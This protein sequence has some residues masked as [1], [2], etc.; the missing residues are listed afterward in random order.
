MD[1]MPTFW[2]SFRGT[3]DFLLMLIGAALPFFLLAGIILAAVNWRTVVL[4]LL[5]TFRPRP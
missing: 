2:E 3:A 1:L 5:N 4:W